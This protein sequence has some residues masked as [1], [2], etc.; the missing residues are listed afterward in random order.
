M[1]DVV[2]GVQKQLTFAVELEGLRWLI[3]FIC[4]LEILGGTLGQLCLRGPHDLVQVLHLAE[5]TLGLV[6]K[7]G[8]PLGECREGLFA[9][10]RLVGS[11]GIH[12]ES[13]HHSFY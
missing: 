9:E 3:D 7:V 8:L 6:H 11:A 13:V 1:L 4:A 12:Q 2:A 5:V 10:E